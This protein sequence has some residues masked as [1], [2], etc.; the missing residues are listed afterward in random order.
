MKWSKTPL[1]FTDGISQLDF[2]HVD[3]SWPFDDLRVMKRNISSSAIFRL[4]LR[5]L[6]EIATPQERLA[7]TI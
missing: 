4:P 5:F 2:V 6:Y 1:S 7:M 3:P